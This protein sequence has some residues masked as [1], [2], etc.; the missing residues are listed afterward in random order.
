VRLVFDLESNGLLDQLDVIHCIGVADLDKP[1]DD[2]RIYH[3][4]KDIEACL[5]LLMSA[6]ELIGHNIIAFDIPALQKV[7]T[8]FKPTAKLT[9]TLVLSRLVAADLINDDAISV[10]LPEDFQKR[11][12]GSHSLKAW[13]LRMG[14]MKG[15]YEGG[16][17]ECNQD[18]LDY[19]VQ[20]VNVTTALHEYLIKQSKDFSQRS[21][22]LEHELAEVCFRI[23]NNGWTFDQEGANEL[24]A[25]LAKLRISLE[26]DLQ[27]LFEPWEIHQEFIPKVNNKSRGYVKGEPFTKVTV[28]E[29]NPNSR[30]HIHRCLVEKYGWKPAEFTP[31]GEAKVDETVLSKLPYPEAQKLA[32]FF[33]VQ[34]RIAQLAEGSQAWMKKVDSDGKIRHTII[35][36]GTVSGRASHRSPNAAQ[37]PST[38]AAF[39]K[40]CRDL[41]TVPKGWTLCGADLSGLELR[42]L[43]HFLEDGGEYAKQILESD[44]HSY[45]Q[46]AAGLKTRDEAKR[47]I[48]SVLF[49]GG[50][51][52]IGQIVGGSAKDGKRL[53]DAFDTNVPAFARLKQELKQAFK[54]GYLKGLDGRK[55]FVRSEHR[56][57]SQLLQSSGAILCKQWLAKIDQEITK[58]GLE[59]YIVGWVH[60]EVQIACRTKEIADHVGDITRRMAQEAGEAFS[61]KIPIEAEYNLGRTWSDTH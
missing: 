11:M 10:S 7:Y 19:C 33:L 43:A 21:L 23:G 46:K 13:G 61:F 9:D 34:K 57:L 6:D 15:D 25:E 17:E 49:G 45:N 20:D 31:S 40:Q 28:V 56:C 16:W 5:K 60:D 27:E 51:K 32:K 58:Q 14:T 22:D 42:C 2:I 12:W 4:D 54:R 47:F 39:G 48:Y 3:G 26:K 59:A 52:L 29:F 53:K 37:V 8:W 24:Y 36:G 38:R 18:M 35:S 44:I 30:K 1:K 50:D 41:W 55:L